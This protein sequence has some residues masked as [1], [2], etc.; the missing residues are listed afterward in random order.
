VEDLLTTRQLQ[1]LL[2]VDRITIYRMLNDGRLRGFKVGG[3]WRFSRREIEA[4]LQE[5]QAGLGRT[6]AP[7][8]PAESP[9]PPSQVLPMTC[10]QAIQAVCAEAL[11]I[12]VVTTGLDGTP[13]AGVSNSCDFCNLIL[14]TESGRLRCA[15]SWRQQLDGQLHACHAGLLCAS[16]PVYVGGQRVANISA[17]QF[18]AQ[19]LNGAPA[20]WT[21]GLATLAADLGLAE[22]D[23]SAAAASIRRV[24]EPALAR[25]SSLV[26]QV[27][28]TLGQIGQ[29]R[30]G[31]VSRLRRIAEITNL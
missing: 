22:A 5:Q 13:L 9:A 25:I 31:L 20:G 17:C 4:W 28:V 14:S 12:A 24:P 21:A 1:N 15:E 29:E 26:E 27:A 10:I 23:L 11:D 19:P 7:S 30:L 6:P 3:Q 8:W 18:V 2:R 16:A